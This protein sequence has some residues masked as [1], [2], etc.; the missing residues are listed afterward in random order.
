MIKSYWK[1]ITGLKKKNPCGFLKYMG[2][3]R[4]LSPRTKILHCSLTHPTNLDKGLS[5]L[6]EDFQQIKS[7]LLL[8]K[9]EKENTWRIKKGSKGTIQYLVVYRNCINKKAEK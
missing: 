4:L 5:K 6:K 9:D 8:K 1:N 3:Q 7:K 2:K